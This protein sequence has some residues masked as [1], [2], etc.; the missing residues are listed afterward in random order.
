MTREEQDEAI[1]QEELAQARERVCVGSTY[2]Q[3]VPSEVRIGI[4][5]ACDQAL[6]ARTEIVGSTLQPIRVIRHHP[7][8]KTN[9]L[10]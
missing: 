3:H 6:P 9:I 5:G 8:R 4:C 10:F 7:D 2:G 1:F